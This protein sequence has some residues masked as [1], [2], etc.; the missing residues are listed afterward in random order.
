MGDQLHQKIMMIIVRGDINRVSFYPDGWWWEPL[1][2]TLTSTR[3]IFFGWSLL[4]AVS[5]PLKTY[6][7][8][9]S[10]QESIECTSNKRGRQWRLMCWI[11]CGIHWRKN[12]S[13]FASCMCACVPKHVLRCCC[14]I[15]SMFTFCFSP[16][17]FIIHFYMYIFLISLKK[18]LERRKL[19]LLH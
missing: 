14:R 1:A 5:W 4:L 16:F 10:A 19:Q 15:N 7:S 18:K 11:Q 13:M 9:S 6:A 3:C 12:I 2:R 8:A 17:P